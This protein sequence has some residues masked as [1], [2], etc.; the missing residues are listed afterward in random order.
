MGSSIRARRKQDIKQKGLSY[1]SLLKVVKTTEIILK[2]QGSTVLS[3]SPFKDK[4][5]TS[6][7][8]DQSCIGV[9][10]ISLM[11][12]KWNKVRGENLEERE[13]MG[14]VRPSSRCN[15]PGGGGGCVCEKGGIQSLERLFSYPGRGPECQG[16]GSRHL[17]VIPRNPQVTVV[18][19]TPGSQGEATSSRCCHP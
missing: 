15:S 1:G 5:D 7:Y 2:T 9:T 14:P 13:S 17:G 11:R 19:A 18:K 6:F 10:R 4:S 3:L 12:Y 8:R 16:S